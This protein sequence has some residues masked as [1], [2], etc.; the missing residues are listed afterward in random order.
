[1]A[2]E[3]REG[4][5]GK[6]GGKIQ[7]SAWLWMYIYTADEFRQEYT[8]ATFLSVGKC[9]N[10]E[11]REPRFTRKKQRGSVYDGHT[12]WYGPV[13]SSMEWKASWESTEILGVD[14]SRYSPC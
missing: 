13:S 4:R 12:A 9:K 6:T 8:F 7:I 3:L 1:M 2:K 5:E 11:I 10:D 14:Q